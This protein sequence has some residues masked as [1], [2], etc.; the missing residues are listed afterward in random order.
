MKTEENPQQD[1]Q[2]KSEVLIALAAHA[3]APPEHP[4]SPDELVDFFKN[5]RRF[6]KQRQ[7]EILAY[8]DSNPEAYER[9][10]KQGK[11]AAQSKRAPSLFSIMPYAIATCM[12]VLSIGI[13][14][15]SRGQ[16]FKLDQAIDHSYQTAVSGDD[17]E[18]FQHTMMSL[19]NSLE[20]PQQPLSFSQSGQSSQ[21][22]QAF[23]LG[24][25]YDW[26]THDPQT[27]HSNHLA[28][29]QQNDY[30][31]GRW[32]ALLWTVSQQSTVMSTDFWQEQLS[33]L[34][35]LQ[36]HYAGRLQGIDTTETKAVALQLEHIHAVL[37]QLAENNQIT[38]PYQQLE[39]TL[40]ALCYSLI[41]S[42]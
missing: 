2:D 40:D 42:L 9:W 20:Q 27:T 30:Q 25:Q 29:A 3:S 4:P 33:I 24:L 21:M 16:G 39:Q 38:K 12:A 1:L 35:H 36:T 7:D 28:N 19:A 6:P 13:F 31:L 17:P 34:S 18:S 32:C 8:L 5:S 15:F 22:A 14:M 23:M 37:K 11:Q 10:I 41:P 26:S